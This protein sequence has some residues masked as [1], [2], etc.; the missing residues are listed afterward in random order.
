M[1]A[2]VFEMIPNRAAWEFFRADSYGDLANVLAGSGSENTPQAPFS[3]ASPKCDNEEKAAI[4][5]KWIL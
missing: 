2:K 1:P 4:Q 3:I 5:T